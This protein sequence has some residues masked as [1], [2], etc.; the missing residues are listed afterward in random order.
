MLEEVVRKKEKKM[1]AK[2]L[3]KSA[4]GPF[5]FLMAIPGMGIPVTL[6]Q[7]LCFGVLDPAGCVW[8]GYNFWNLRYMLTIGLSVIVVIRVQTVPSQARTTF[9]MGSSSPWHYY[10]TSARNSYPH[11]HKFSHSCKSGSGRVTFP[12]PSLLIRLT[13]S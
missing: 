12:W 4:Q 7:V 2:R 6:C 13:F 11:F 8:W 3:G 1:K 9:L 10:S 5:T